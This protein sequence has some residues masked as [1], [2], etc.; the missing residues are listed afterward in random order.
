MNY[1]QK[2]LDDYKHQNF[3]KGVFCDSLIL[4]DITCKTN[5]YDVVRDIRVVVKQLCENLGKEAIGTLNFDPFDL[6]K[7]LLEQVKS[8]SIA[9]NFAGVKNEENTIHFRAVVY[10]D[11][12]GEERAKIELSEKA[13][14]TMMGYYSDYITLLLYRFYARVTHAKQVT[15]QDLIKL[16]RYELEDLYEVMKISDAIE[17]SLD[18][19][20]T[21]SLRSKLN[22]KVK[23]YSKNY[24]NYFEMDI[25][26]VIASNKNIMHRRGQDVYATVED[27]SSITKK[28]TD[29]IIRD[30]TTIMNN[31]NKVDPNVDFRSIYKETYYTTSKNREVRTFTMSEEGFVL[32][33]CHYDVTM[34][35]MLANF[36]VE[37]KKVVVPKITELIAASSDMVYDAIQ[38]YNECDKFLIQLV[39]VNHNKGANYVEQKE[40]GIIE[41]LN[42]FRASREQK[43]FRRWDPDMKYDD[44]QMRSYMVTPRYMDL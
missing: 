8:N 7:N 33:I 6:E 21:E 42:G 32:L 20:E 29:N 24:E 17:S 39:G 12:K 4:R 30:I 26:L 14:L 34:I 11:N 15:V 40:K 37:M 43:L 27:V 2:I 31:I 22:E 44:R 28:R 10:K 35:W 13:Y 16:N 38:Y 18:T 19:K 5:H 41:Q 3:E 25:M 1:L 23:D 36:Y 9:L